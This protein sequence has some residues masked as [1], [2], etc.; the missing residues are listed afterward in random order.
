MGAGALAQADLAAG[1]PGAPPRGA[2]PARTRETMP[3][4]QTSVDVRPNSANGFTFAFLFPES[5]R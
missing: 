3:D 2:R 1:G 4:V 5:L